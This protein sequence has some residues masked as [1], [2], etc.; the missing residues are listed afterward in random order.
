MG[1]GVLSRRDGTT[2]GGVR[3]DASIRNVI[4]RRCRRR[5]RKRVMKSLAAVAACSSHQ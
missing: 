5:R 4:R 2:T 1:W 3:A